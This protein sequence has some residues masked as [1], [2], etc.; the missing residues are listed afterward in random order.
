M[1]SSNE[2]LAFLKDQ[3]NGVLQA[4]QK[5]QKLGYGSSGVSG[6]MFCC[7]IRRLPFQLNEFKYMHSR[8]LEQTPE[9]CGCEWFR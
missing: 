6:G 4:S 1:M 2:T 9:S 7:W 5:E 3:N 8:N